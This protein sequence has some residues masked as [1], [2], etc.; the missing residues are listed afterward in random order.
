[1]KRRVAVFDFDGTLTNKDTLLAFIKFSC[2][3][4]YLYRGLILYSPILI[5]M[6]LGLYPNWRAKEKFFS[7]FFK[8][9]PY[10][11]FKKEGELFAEE[12]EKFSNKKMVSLLVSHIGKGD[13]VYVISASI[14][15]WVRPWCSQIGDIS[16]LGTKIEVDGRGLLTGR[17]LTRNCYGQEKV[18]R[19]L[20]EEPDRRDYNLYAYGDSRG[21]KEM[22][23]FADYGTLI[24]K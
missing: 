23:A 14:E 22:I 3:K 17:F 6:R 1:M 20:A 19:L 16:V 2:G 10:D 11:Q 4:I 9:T 18:N 12:I 21:D 5:L 7:F 24:T 13:K 8:G 15:E